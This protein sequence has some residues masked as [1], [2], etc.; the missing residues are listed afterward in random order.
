MLSNPAGS[1]RETILHQWESLDKKGG[2]SDCK[3]FM[4]GFKEIQKKEPGN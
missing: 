2:H 3:L 1:H 4:K